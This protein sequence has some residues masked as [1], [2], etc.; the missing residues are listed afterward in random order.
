MNAKEEDVIEAAAKEEDDEA[1]AASTRAPLLLRKTM[2]CEVPKMWMG[3]VDE[4][5]RVLRCR[6]LAFN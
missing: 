4:I 2:K 5:D 6:D 3:M 1:A